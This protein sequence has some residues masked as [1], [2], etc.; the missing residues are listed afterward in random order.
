MGSVVFK[1]ESWQSTV[2]DDGSL[3]RGSKL[4]FVKRDKGLTNEQHQSHVNEWPISE[5]HGKGYIDSIQT[6][7]SPSN[8]GMS[9]L[10]FSSAEPLL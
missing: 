8:N 10:L 3:L 6:G 2:K 5:L 1:P 7:L 9:S 4:V